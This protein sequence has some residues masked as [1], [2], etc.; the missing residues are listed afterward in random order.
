MVTHNNHNVICLRVRRLDRGD[1]GADREEINSAVD[2][3]GYGKLEAEWR[4]F[5][6]PT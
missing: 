2:I 4:Y 6:H 5:A 3:Q 1:H